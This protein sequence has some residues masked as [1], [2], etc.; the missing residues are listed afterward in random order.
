MVKD[1]T[2]VSLKLA[3]EKYLRRVSRPQNKKHKDYHKRL[4]MPPFEFM[5]EERGRLLK[6]YLNPTFKIEQYVSIYDWLLCAYHSRT[7]N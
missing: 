2:A 4:Q 3:G 1:V 5:T 6:E 7:E